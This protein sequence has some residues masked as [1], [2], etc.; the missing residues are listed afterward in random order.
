MVVAIEGTD[1]GPPG[2]HRD[3]A[4]KRA[5][6]LHAKPRHDPVNPGFDELQVENQ[7]HGARACRREHRVWH[8]MKAASCSRFRGRRASA[9]RWSSHGSREDQA[10]RQ[11][12]FPDRLMR[13]LG[14]SF[15][16]IGDSY[17][18]AVAV[19]EEKRRHIKLRSDCCRKAG[20]DRIRCAEFSN[21]IDPVG[22]P[23]RRERWLEDNWCHPHAHV[24]P[25]TT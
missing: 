23:R 7:R 19:C 24:N 11:R 18:P 4:D 8:L 17:C 5:P 22:Y 16:G 6:L 3:S 12:Q 13:S 1:P 25:E 20:N 10:S 9:A 2:S 14:T 21:R 15:F